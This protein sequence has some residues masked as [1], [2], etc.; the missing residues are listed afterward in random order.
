[1]KEIIKNS[2]LTLK[3]FAEK[4]EIPYNTVRQWNNAERQA[5]NWIKKLFNNAKNTITI[6]Q[7]YEYYTEEGLKYR[8]IIKKDSNEEQKD[9]FNRCQSKF[10]NREEGLKFKKIYQLIEG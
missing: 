10:N 3:E 6:E 1:M 9:W 5:P 2:G 4:Y 7:L 8:A